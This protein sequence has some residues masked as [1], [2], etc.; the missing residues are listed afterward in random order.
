MRT[1][2]LRKMVDYLIQQRTRSSQT[3]QFH[4]EVVT[5]EG[6]VQATMLTLLS[7]DHAILTALIALLEEALERKAIV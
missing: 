3:Y 4:S 5:P 1:P 7:N 6:S 2:E